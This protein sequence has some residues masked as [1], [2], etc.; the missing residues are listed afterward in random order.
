MQAL[1]AAYAIEITI[2]QLEAI[3]RANP[4][5]V[6]V[7]T[8]FTRALRKR[9]KKIREETLQI[10]QDMGRIPDADVKT[11]TQPL[12]NGMEDLQKIVITHSG[13]AAEMGRSRIQ[14]LLKKTK[15]PRKKA[16]KSIA[17]KEAKPG[18][19]I[20]P[21]PGNYN[22]PF[23]TGP[24]WENAK[25]K[26]IDKSISSTEQSWHRMTDDITGCLSDAYNDKLT[27]D[28]TK[29]KL[30]TVME[31]M[32]RYELERIART[33]TNGAQNAAA[34]DTIDELGLDFEQWW[35]SQDDRVRGFN[36][37]DKADHMIMHGQ[38]IR[39]GGTF[40]NGLKY[41][42]DQS[43]PIEEWILCR[44]ILVPFL[45]PEGLMAPPGEE[46]FY[47]SDLVLSDGTRQPVEDEGP[48]PAEIKPPEEPVTIQDAEPSAP[49]EKLPRRKKG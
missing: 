34:S 28:Q 46:Y 13:N 31:G 36:P 4:R 41:P 30:G 11:L 47:E 39:V 29:A 33:I 7:E 3:K 25:Q 15:K 17:E 21:T 38:I 22:T 35:T 10:L 2:Q 5:I 12:V 48:A 8:R 42:G 43:G 24:V 49:G 32:E 16:G 40:S 6:Q 18:G 44:C 9:F 19:V 26:I 20:G 14:A 1:E 27:L 45:M 37:K 23:E